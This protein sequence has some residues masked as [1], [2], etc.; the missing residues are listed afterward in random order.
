[1]E[2]FREA[3]RALLSLGLV[4][5]TEGNLSTFDGATLWITRTGA[6]LGDLG[7]GDVL[8]GGLDGPLDGAS[9]DLEVHRRL[10][11]KRG[12]GAIVHAHPPGTVPEGGGGPG[13][14]G[15]YVFAATL[16]EAVE[17]VVEEARQRSEL[18]RGPSGPPAPGGGGSW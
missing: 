1:V 18:D 7:G 10:Y 13:E 5:G 9:G 16:P 2:A 11:A 4:R 12:P 15:T 17:A 14:H 8:E 3:G 6:P